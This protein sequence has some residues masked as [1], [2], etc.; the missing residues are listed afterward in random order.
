MGLASHRA[1][2]SSL[3]PVLPTLP[4]DVWRPLADAH[5]ARV[6]ALT[7]GHRERRGRDAAHP[8]EDFLWRYYS[9]RPASLRHWLPVA[10]TGLRD[11]PERAGDKFH[12]G[13]A[14]VVRLDVAGFVRARG[15][16][17]RFVRDLV[18]ATLERPAQLG[19]FGLHEWAMVYRSGQVRHEQ[20]PLRLGRE[21]TDEVVRG[22][23][24]RCSHHD[25]YRFFTPDARPLNT[26][27]PTREGQV[28]MEQPG[29][30]HAGMD[31]Y[32]HCYKLWPAISSDLTLACFELAREL[33]LLDM[34]ASP[35]DLSAFGHE[36]V[37]IETAA[38]KTAYLERQRAFGQRSNVLRERL[39]EVLGSVSPG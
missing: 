13:A 1:C 34:Q 38:G 6:D 7:A 21:G 32:K 27:S 22:H 26:L 24:I 17:V 16:S 9:F 36:P 30:L 37:P 29:C 4:A 3:R 11:A 19:C 35:Y 39:L 31:L 10:G 28:A 12:R 5:A 20:L 15:R 2:S 14:G 8:I 25:A 18:A 23:T 33:R